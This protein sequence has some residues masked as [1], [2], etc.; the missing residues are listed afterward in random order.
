MNCYTYILYSITLDKYYVGHSCIALEERL[1]KHNTNHKGYTGK[2]N[3]WEVVYFEIFDSK[4]EAYSRE[5][6]IKSKK[7][8][9]HITKLIAG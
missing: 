3:D 2:T 5:R 8:K 7:S 9:K 6:E 1:K 4:K